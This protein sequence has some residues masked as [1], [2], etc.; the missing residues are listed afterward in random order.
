MYGREI[1]AQNEKQ[2]WMGG[3]DA[4]RLFILSNLMKQHTIHSFLF[5]FFLIH[6][7]SYPLIFLY[8]EST[9]EKNKNR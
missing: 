2:F 1:G 3:L 9:R 7:L 6:I 4:E 8:H 5:F